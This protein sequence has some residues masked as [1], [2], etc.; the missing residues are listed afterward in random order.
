MKDVKKLQNRSGFT[1]IEM[2]V[3][4]L[5]I[6]LLSGMILKI[7]EV[8]TGKAARARAVADITNLQNAISEYYSKYNM[9]P[10]TSLTGYEFEN[11]AGQS[12]GLRSTLRNANNP[13]D[14]SFIT[15]TQD[16][17]VDKKSERTWGK[18]T[19]GSLGYR[20]GLVSYLYPREQGV[21][22]HWYSGD[23]ADDVAAKKS[24][25]HF[26]KDVHTKKWGIEHKKLG[27]LEIT[28]PYTN[29][30]MTVVD[31][32]E[33]EYKYESKPPYQ[34]YKLWSVGPDGKSGTADDV[35]NDS[36]TE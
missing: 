2:L 34:Q 29:S 11:I 13:E 35:N 30:Y 25:A 16:R 12:E 6:L 8:V 22:A 28:Q 32:W 7:S 20:Y 3:V 4:I 31:P 17:V 18:S 36:F 33:H 27:G 19:K 21:Q 26:L 5:V 9:Y 14:G 24:W 15:D 10:D 23:T 1:L